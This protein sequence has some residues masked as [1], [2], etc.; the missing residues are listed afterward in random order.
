LHR[1]HIH[2]YDTKY[3]LFGLTF[4]RSLTTPIQTRAETPTARAYDQSR[5]SLHCYL[6]SNCTSVLDV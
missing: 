6:D 2:S 3:R 5:K 1:T 4:P